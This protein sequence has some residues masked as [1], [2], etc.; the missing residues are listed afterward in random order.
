MK[1]KT[2]ADARFEPRVLRERP[3]KPE[4]AALKRKST[5][6]TAAK[7]VVEEKIVEEETG[8]A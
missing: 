7:K 3:A 2:A 5:V 4:P 8:E 6:T 1:R